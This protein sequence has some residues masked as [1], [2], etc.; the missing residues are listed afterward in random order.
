MLFEN[1]KQLTL[2]LLPALVILILLAGYPVASV[3][4]NAFGQVDY[5]HKLY[6]FVGLAN[7]RELF[8]DFFFLSAIS[9]TCVFT[10]VASLL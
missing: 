2:L 6:S 8:S 9:N 5:V 4:Y 10:L 1:R 7:F 3:I